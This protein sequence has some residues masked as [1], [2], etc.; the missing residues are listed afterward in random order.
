M[1][2]V[3][4]ETLFL[5]E[6]PARMMLT[7]KRAGKPIYAAVLSK[8]TDSTY[9][10]TLRVLSKLEELGLVR[11]EE[12]GR[13]KLVKLTELGD[14]IANEFSSLLVMLELAEVASAIEAIYARDVK[15]HLREEINKEAAL[16]RLGQQT[17]KLERLMNERPEVIQRLVKK[18]LKRIDEISREVKGLIVGQ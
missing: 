10:H 7:L 3:E 2:K 4:V 1:A 14:V 18:Q 17:K 5:Q 11:F 8:E 9:A 12:Q 6:K 16:N 13:I 15:G